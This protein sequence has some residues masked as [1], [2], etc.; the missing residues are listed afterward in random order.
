[1]DAA[2]LAAATA[3]TSLVIGMLI[4]ALLT[5]FIPRFR[6]KEN[7]SLSADAYERPDFSNV[8]HL[9]EVKK[10]ETGQYAELQLRNEQTRKTSDIDVSLYSNCE[11]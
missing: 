11:F 10:S 8:S 5:Y 6:Q 1:M 9:G 4:G 7:K 2:T 3:V